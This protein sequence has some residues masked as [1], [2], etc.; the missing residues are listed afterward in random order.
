MGFL[1][2]SP[3]KA[4]DPVS[5]ASDPKK[6]ESASNQ[7]NVSKK[8]SQTLLPAGSKNSPSSK[9]ETNISSDSFQLDLSKREGIF[10]GNVEV[11]SARF[12]LKAKELVMF[13]GEDSKP[14]RFVARGDVSIQSGD[15]A[16]IA[17]QAEYDLIEKKI[18]LTGD[19]AVKQ[20]GNRVSGNSIIIYP[21][22]DRMDVIG[23]TS[24][25]FIQ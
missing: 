9:A 13:L 11:T 18:T 25:R 10:S 1:S 16:A 15:R 17:R 2:L 3:L 19:P 24:L 14:E 5:A 22:N 21:E 7:E 6:T 4:A 8:E 23:R 12:N 20:G